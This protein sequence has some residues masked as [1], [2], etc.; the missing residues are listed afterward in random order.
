MIRSISGCHGVTD[1]VRLEVRLEE[2]R[3]VASGTV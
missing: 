1:K 3:E 2:E